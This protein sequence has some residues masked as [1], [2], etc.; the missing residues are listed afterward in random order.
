MERKKSPDST[1]QKAIQQHVV[2][3]AERDK[4]LKMLQLGTYT[5]ITFRKLTKSQSSIGLIAKSCPCIIQF[6][7]QGGGGGGGFCNSCDTINKSKIWV[8]EEL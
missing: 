7:F 1:V 4:A 5:M 3:H 6:F 2:E 8:I